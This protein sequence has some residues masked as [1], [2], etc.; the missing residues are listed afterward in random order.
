MAATQAAKSVDSK[1]KR[2]LE[3]NEGNVR[4]K[5]KVKR[6]GDMDGI[7]R[8]ADEENMDPNEHSHPLSPPNL[9][10]EPCAH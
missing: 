2:A 7:I 6:T 10:K 3:A 4:K 9:R 8:P 1:P 5:K